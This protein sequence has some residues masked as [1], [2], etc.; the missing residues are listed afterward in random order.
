M[1]AAHPL[2]DRAVALASE[3]G[4]GEKAAVTQLA[5]AGDRHELEGARHYLVWR[6][7]Q[8]TDDYQA[9]AALNLV[10]KALAQVGWYDPYPWKHRRKP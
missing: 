5:A 3:A 4:P 10:N 9:T 8:C 1:A 2:A 6:L 7:Q